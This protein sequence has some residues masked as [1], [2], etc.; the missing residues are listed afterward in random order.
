MPFK[1]STPND[2]AG[3]VFIQITETVTNAFIS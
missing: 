1:A 2:P 3:T